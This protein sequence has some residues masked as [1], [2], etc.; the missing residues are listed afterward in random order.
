MDAD[1][2]PQITQKIKADE[3]EIVVMYAK[4]RKSKRNKHLR[5]AV[6]LTLTIPIMDSRKRIKISRRLSIIT[7]TSGICSQD[8]TGSQ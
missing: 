4:H 3:I 6:E 2:V 8:C 1:D 7:K 5:L